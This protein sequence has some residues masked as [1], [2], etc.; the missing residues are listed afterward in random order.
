MVAFFKS[1]CGLT[2]SCDVMVAFSWS[3]CGLTEI[4][5]T[6]PLWKFRCG[7]SF[8]SWRQFRGETST[9]IVII[10]GELANKIKKHYISLGFFLLRTKI[11]RFLL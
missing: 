8:C 10:K 7:R 3:G 5:M 4:Q 11:S 9:Y 6:S 1:G 2:G